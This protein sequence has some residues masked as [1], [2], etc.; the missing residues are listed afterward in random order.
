MCQLLLLLLLHLPMVVVLGLPFLLARPRESIHL[1]EL[2]REPV[3]HT[4]HF[5]LS[6][7][8]H[9]QPDTAPNE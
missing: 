4:A 3:G 2:C 6:S 8:V 1:A 7:P 9:H 5:P